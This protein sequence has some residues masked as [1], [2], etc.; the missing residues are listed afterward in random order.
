MKNAKLF[1]IGRDQAI[2]LPK[3][4]R[5]SC[6][7]VN[8]NKICDTVILTPKNSKWDSFA[9]A[10]QMFSDDYMEDIIK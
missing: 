9:R 1:K 5:F 8:I 7:E 10:V 4:Y 3:N 6:D 2:R